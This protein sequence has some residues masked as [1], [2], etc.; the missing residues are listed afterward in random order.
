VREMGGEREREREERWGERD[1]EGGK[2]RER[3]S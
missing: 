1:K 2:E 3:E